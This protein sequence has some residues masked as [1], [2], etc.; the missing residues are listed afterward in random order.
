M[1]EAQGR[2]AARAH[3]SVFEPSSQH[4]DVDKKIVASLERL[5]QVFRILLRGGLRSVA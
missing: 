2:S 3:R 4:S 1:G 5:S